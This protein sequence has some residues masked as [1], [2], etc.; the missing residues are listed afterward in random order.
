M[1]HQTELRGEVAGAAEAASITD[2]GD[3]RGRVL[4]LRSK[5]AGIRYILGLP[6]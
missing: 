5:L 4:F 3:Q 6:E 2:R 1:G